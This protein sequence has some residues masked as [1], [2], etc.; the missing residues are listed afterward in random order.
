[1]PA[2]ASGGRRAVGSRASRRGL[3]SSTVGPCCRPRGPWSAASDPSSPPA[4][5]H[6]AAVNR[7][8]SASSVRVGR[9]SGPGAPRSTADHATARV[10]GGEERIEISASL[11]ITSIGWSLQNSHFR[12]CPGRRPGCPSCRARRGR[13][14]CSSRGSRP[15]GRV[16]RRGPGGRVRGT[17][18][19]SPGGRSGPRTT[20][21][22]PT[23]LR[24]TAAATRRVSRSPAMTNRVA[25]QAPAARTTGRSVSTRGSLATKGAARIAPARRPAPPRTGPP[26]P[27]RPG[28]APTRPRQRRTSRAGV[29]A[30]GRAAG[31]S[32]PAWSRQGKTTVRRYLSRSGERRSACGA[33]GTQPKNANSPSTA[34]CRRRSRLDQAVVQAR[35]LRPQDAVSVV[36]DQELQVERAAVDDRRRYQGAPTATRTSHQGCTRNVRSDAVSRWKV[37][38]EQDRGRQQQDDAT[39][40]FVRVAAREDGESVQRRAAEVVPRGRR[41]R[42]LPARSVV[43][44]MS[45]RSATDWPR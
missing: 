40:P 42:R 39:G 31:R 18:D 24:A 25:P 7:S 6:G 41:R 35:V 43:N 8:P 29:P 22:R 1:M 3:R 36:V 16:G 28:A 26:P 14:V 19:P 17:R 9:T 45:V 20:A 4:Q 27:P 2:P 37:S 15:R 30:R 12:C 10:A 23:A 13:S 33:P 5:R 34:A 38:Q 21:S 44:T 11:A 32:S